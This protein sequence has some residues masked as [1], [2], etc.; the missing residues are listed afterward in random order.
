MEKF[1]IMMLEFSW[2]WG[3]LIYQRGIGVSADHAV[4]IYNVEKSSSSKMEDV[5]DTYVPDC[6]AS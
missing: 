4:T 3:L 2:M 1:K 5:I 6:M